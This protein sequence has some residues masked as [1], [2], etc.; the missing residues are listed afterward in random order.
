MVLFFKKRKRKKKEEEKVRK[1]TKKKILP[2]SLAA[3]PLK[4]DIVKTVHGDWNFVIKL[5]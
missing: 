2:Q 5:S 3:Q 1:N 4:S